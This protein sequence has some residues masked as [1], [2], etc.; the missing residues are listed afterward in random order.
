MIIEGATEKV[1]LLVILLKSI[2]KIYCVVINK[3]AFLNTMK[4]LK[5]LIFFTFGIFLFKKCSTYIFRAA[6]VRLF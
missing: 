2:K 6:S 4:I 5:Q 1:S 3:N